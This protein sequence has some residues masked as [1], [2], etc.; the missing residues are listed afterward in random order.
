MICPSLIIM[1]CS[2]CG[3]EYERKDGFG[4]SRHSH[5]ICRQCADNLMIE[6]M[7]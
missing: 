4:M 7:L 3:E 5:G 1:V 6:V 2:Y